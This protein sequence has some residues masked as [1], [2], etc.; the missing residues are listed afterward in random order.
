M[1]IIKGRFIVCY[2]LIIIIFAFL[3]VLNYAYFFLP[4]TPSINSVTLN[5]YNQI[6]VKY[7][8]PE[9]KYFKDVYCLITEEDETPSINDDGWYKAS[10]NECTALISDSTYHMYIKSDNNEIVEAKEAYSLGKVLSLTISKE[11]IYLAVNGT[12]SV[13]TELS[14]VG[15]IDKTVTWTSENEGIATV[16]ENGN[17][18]GTGNGETKINATVMDTVVSTTVIVT[19]LLVPR[20]Y[21]FDYSKSYLGCDYYSKEDNDLIDKILESRVNDVGYATRAGVVEAARFLTL[22]FPYRLSYFSENGRLTY[23]AK[24]DAE[25][26]YY[27][28]GLYLDE[29]RFSSIGNKRNGPKTWGCNMYNAV[30]HRTSRNGFDCSGFVSWVLLNGGFDPGDIGAGVTSAYDLT[31]TGKRTVFNQ[32]VVNSNV[33][34]TGDLLSSPNAGGGHIAIIVGMDDTYYYV[35]ESLWTGKQMGVVIMPY[36]K[37]T[38]YKRYYYVILMDDYYKEDGNYTV[39]W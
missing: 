39:H 25:G 3:L 17:I 10:N 1:C 18:K 2:S 32:S 36:N 34:K 31:D 22:E 6:I 19:N 13:T 23:S 4:P 27:H 37:N 29:S 24:I 8:I 35:A 11:L 26:R 38:A 21:S 15:N 30:S 33:V 16:D 9:Y 5:E 28:K 20:P 14:S 7:S 12:S